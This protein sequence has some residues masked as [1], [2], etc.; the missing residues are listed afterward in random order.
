[1]F[2]VIYFLLRFIPFWAIPVMLISMQF[3]YI[4]W[5]K[6]VRW[7]AFI[8]GAVV[9]ICLLLI[10]YYFYAGSPD[11]SAQYFQEFIRRTQN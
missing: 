5:L 1:M 11:N 9:L 7:I 3:C 10:I 2:D 8:L 6:E 4:Y